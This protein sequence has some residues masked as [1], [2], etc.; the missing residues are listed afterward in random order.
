MMASIGEAIL[1]ASNLLGLG[2]LRSAAVASAM[3]AARGSAITP[4]RPEV[5]QPVR[6]PETRLQDRVAEAVATALRDAGYLKA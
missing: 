2:A 3:P 6:E 5:P 4:H 1:A